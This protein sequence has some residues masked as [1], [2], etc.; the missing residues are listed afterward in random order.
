[1]E[2]TNVLLT[3]TKDGIGTIT[4]NRPERR[5]A[6]SPEML[7]GIHETLQEWGTHDEVR[8]VVITGAG[9]KAFSG[10]YDIAAIPTNLTPETEKLLRDSNA[11]D[12]GLKSVKD[13]PYPTIAMINGHCFGGALNLA[14]CC[15]TRIAADGVK[16]GMPPAKLGVV[17]PPDGMAQFVQI[18][19]MARAREIFFTGRTYQGIE[20]KEM[21]LVDRLVPLS[22]LH[23]T[24]YTLAEEITANAP[25]SLK[26]LK[27]ILNL[28]E[29]SALL[30]AGA[31]AEAESLV[32][33]ALASEDLK[34]GQLAFLEK[35]KPSFVGR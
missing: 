22:E 33:A 21:G 8:T 35:R 1:M 7:I 27:R 2:A 18:V 25:L 26:G 20:V 6:L 31:R 19:G 16:I 32:A 12:I 23:G 29:E 9:D 24:V 34:E 30:S 28:I 5:N 10:G 15:D 17:Y 13:F 4:L 11:L 14:I 3:E